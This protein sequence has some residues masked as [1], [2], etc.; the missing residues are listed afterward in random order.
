MGKKWGQGGVDSEWGARN[1]GKNEAEGG[2]VPVADDW[3]AQNQGRKV[4][5][6]GF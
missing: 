3:E 6:R 2:E 5:Q 1:G 4:V